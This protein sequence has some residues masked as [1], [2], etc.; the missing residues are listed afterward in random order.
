MGTYNFSR[1][2]EEWHCQP[3]FIPVSALACDDPGYSIAIYQAPEAVA[4]WRV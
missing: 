2:L 4:P 3:Y 1:A